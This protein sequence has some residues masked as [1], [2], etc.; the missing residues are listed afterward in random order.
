M[1]GVTYLQ[2]KE[3]KEKEHG[4]IIVRIFSNKCLWFSEE[5]VSSV[6]VHIEQYIWISYSAT[7]KVTLD[8]TNLWRLS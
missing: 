6:G 2:R 8:V 7:L 4:T 5:Q 1:F 3:N